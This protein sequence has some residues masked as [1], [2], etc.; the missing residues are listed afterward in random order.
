[1]SKVPATV[2]VSGRW[3]EKHWREAKELADEPLIEFGNHSYR[4]PAFSRLDASP[5][6]ARR[7]TPPIG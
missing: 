6:C 7:S 3:V 5:R 4:H 1:M 2:F